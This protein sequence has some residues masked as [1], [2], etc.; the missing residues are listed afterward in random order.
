[1]KRRVF[2]CQ[3]AA[4]PELFPPR[5]RI[6]TTAQPPRVNSFHILSNIAMSNAN[7]FDIPS[8][9]GKPPVGLH[10]DVTKDG[11]LIQKLMIDQ[12][13]C[14]FFGRNKELSDF[15]VPHDSCSRVHAAL[16]W[17]KHLNRPFLIDLGSTHGT[18]IGRMRMEA[19]KPT[20][21]P[22]DRYAIPIFASFQY[23]FSM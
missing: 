21:V 11:K 14:Y 20:Q 18:W 17:H 12:K 8:W 1:M 23:V 4:F 6:V 3:Y 2:I 7:N 10:L 15:H 19:K 9:A 5:S 16:V 22:P 13:K